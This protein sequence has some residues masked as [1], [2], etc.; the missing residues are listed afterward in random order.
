MDCNVINDYIFEKKKIQAPLQAR[1]AR[2]ADAER[3][4]RFLHDVEDEE[5]WIREKE[6]I[7]SSKNTGTWKGLLCSVFPSL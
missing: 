5:A 2:L 4:K 1:K 6:P 3:L 7:A